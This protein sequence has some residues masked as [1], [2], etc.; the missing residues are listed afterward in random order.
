MSLRSGWTRPSRVAAATLSRGLPS[1]TTNNRANIDGGRVAGRPS[2]GTRGCGR[3]HRG[4]RSCEGGGGGGG[5]KGDIRVRREA[6]PPPPFP[7]RA[8]PSSRLASVPLHLVSV[9]LEAAWASA[10]THAP[11]TAGYL[12][13]AFPSPRH[14]RRPW[15]AGRHWG[16]RD[17]RLLLLHCFH[18]EHALRKPRWL[19]GAS[20]LPVRRRNIRR[21]WVSS[22]RHIPPTSE[23]DK[24][25]RVRVR[26]TASFHDCSLGVPRT[27]LLCLGARSTTFRAVVTWTTDVWGF[28]GD[29]N[30]RYPAA[31]GHVAVA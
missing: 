25:G 22:S 24:D 27:M 9:R 11:P 3:R 2:G 14:A 1:S 21:R 23:P 15:R 18:P 17:R 12:V 30:H 6:P 13:P 26:G 5:G 4:R 20:Y 28:L 10:W 31:A 16:R 19:G 8:T 29:Y 7:I